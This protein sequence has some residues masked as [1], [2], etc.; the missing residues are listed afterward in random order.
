MDPIKKAFFIDKM[1]KYNINIT[2]IDDLIAIKIYNCWMNDKFEDIDQLTLVEFSYMC[3]YL[4]DTNK[5]FNIEIINKLINNINP[6]YYNIL[7]TYYN[8]FL[9]TETDINISIELV[10][11]EYEKYKFLNLLNLGNCHEYDLN[12]G[13]AIDA[14]NEHYDKTGD[15]TALHKLS[16][17]YLKINK[18]N[19]LIE[20]Y[21][22]LIYVGDITVYIEYA[23]LCKKLEQFDKMIELYTTG[24]ELGCDNCM[25]ELS[26]YFNSYKSRLECL[27]KSAIKG[28]PIAKNMFI[29][30]VSN[31]IRTND[32]VSFDNF[33]K[34]LDLYISYN[35]IEFDIKIIIIYIT[36]GYID[37]ACTYWDK[38]VNNGTTLLSTSYYLLLSIQS[39]KFF[40]PP[41]NKFIGNDVNIVHILYEYAT[42][43]IK[44]KIYEYIR[45]NPTLL[46]MFKYT[47]PIRTTHMNNFY[48][49]IYNSGV[50]SPLS[51]TI[52]VEKFKNIFKNRSKYKISD[53]DLK[54]ILNTTLNDT[55][56][57]WLHLLK[58]LLI[59][60]IT[61][62][63][64]IESFKP[65]NDGF[66]EAKEHYFNT[67]IKK[68][69]SIENVEMLEIPKVDEIITEINNG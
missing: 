11:Q 68:S 13:L 52:I 5:I 21:E 39:G 4:I 69:P 61:L 48:E 65:G 49:I 45:L 1:I 26:L 24:H 58:N 16:N 28:H 23:N 44:Q 10:N 60:Q 8:K 15:I 33:A 18:I 30:S 67:L 57:I 20:T 66:L 54:L 59:K 14:Y 37:K 46:E 6:I 17:I 25:Y 35:N 7:L 55:T 34:Y 12:I 41:T 31:H 53:K 51:I 62:I 43:E 38:S 3:L 50:D 64:Y 40:I 2:N 56:P 42:P 27:Y 29:E 19:N 36:E 47:H 63:D 9:N 22:K 32:Y